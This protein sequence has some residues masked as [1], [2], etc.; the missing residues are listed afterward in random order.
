MGSGL[1]FAGASCAYKC[2]ESF[3]VWFSAAGLLQVV[4]SPSGGAH[5][6]EVIPPQTQTPAQRD[7]VR[8]LLPQAEASWWAPGHSGWTVLPLDTQE[9]Q[10]T[11][12]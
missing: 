1:F 10:V 12:Q 6:V 4:L 8:Q 7:V 2:V 3:C 9:F 5:Q 11:W